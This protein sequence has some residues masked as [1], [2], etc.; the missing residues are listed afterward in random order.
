MVVKHKSKE[1]YDQINELSEDVTITLNGIEVDAYPY[2]DHQ[3]MLLESD[4]RREY[5]PAIE[6]VT[7]A[8]FK[9]TILNKNGKF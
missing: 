3:V 2:K 5:N 8:N 1:L 4:M 9:N 7:L 6:I